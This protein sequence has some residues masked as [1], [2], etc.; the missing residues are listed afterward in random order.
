MR[1]P[2][3][4]TEV[5]RGE[6]FLFEPVENGLDYMVSVVQLLEGNPTSRDLKYAVLHLCAALEVL[7]KARLLAEDWTLVFEDTKGATKEALET[8]AFRSVGI[9]DAVSRLRPLGILISE[10]D[11]SIILR[12]FDK[13]NALQH[14]GLADSADA[15]LATA[16]AALNI[17]VSFIDRHLRESEPD[18][19]AQAIDDV[20]DGLS[21]IDEFVEV[22][23]EELA[24]V[25]AEIP[26]VVECPGC[27]QM[28]LELGTPCVCL[29]C[30]KE[31]PPERVAEEYVWEIF[32]E[33]EYEAAKGRTS[34]SIHECPDCGS[35]VL[36]GGITN[37]NNRDTYWCCFAEGWGLTYDAISECER[38]GTLASA[39]M[40]DLVLCENCLQDWILG[41]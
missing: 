1:G 10:R 8:G 7:L 39:G 29:F 41:D 24:D 30:L 9:K 38:C 20:R 26:V 37:A 40:D 22:R 11:H 34:W 13:R 16:A 4:P 27:S 19:T 32:Q 31:G 6:D 35:E 36:V 25:L 5:P 15:V 33:S 17:L 14:F 28:A 2:A 3:E 12:A 21:R 23:L 18:R